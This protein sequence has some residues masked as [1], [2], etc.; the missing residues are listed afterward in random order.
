MP[1]TKRFNNKTTNR[2]N[3]RKRYGAKKS[4]AVIAK[5]RRNRMV[6]LIKDIQVSQVERKYKSK[7][8]A[9]TQLF[10][11]NIYQYHIWG[12]TGNILDCMPTQGT[13]DSHRLGDRIFLE[14]F[15]V[16]A[17]FAIAGDRRNTSVDIYYVPHNSDHGNPSSDLFHSV[18]GSVMVDPIQKKRYPKA[19]KLGR[20]HLTPSN[21]WY[22]GSVATVSEN[23]G[24]IIVQKWIP[25]NKKVFFNADADNK[26]TNLS[27]YGTLCICPYQ[28]WKTLE[29]DGLIVGGDLNVTAYFKDL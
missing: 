9:V 23:T 3:Y 10:H 21:Q 17:S 5:Y 20:Y 19:Y 14:G 11:N 25:I 29:T 2:R 7:N 18:T 13:S 26:P 4:N 15:M 16:R 1:G 24:T 28:S 8:F 6:K 27:E 12:E 22:L